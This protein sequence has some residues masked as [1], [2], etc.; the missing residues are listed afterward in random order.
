M[1]AS[2]RESVVRMLDGERSPEVFCSVPLTS[3]TWDQMEA[4]NVYYPDAHMDPDLMVKLAE[5]AYTLLGFQGVRSGF[6]SGMEAEAFGAEVNLGSRQNNVSVTKPAFDDPDAFAIPKNLFELGRFPVRFKAL[7]ILHDKYRDEVPIY[8]IV[9]GPMTLTGNLFGV[10]KIMRWI[11]KEQ[12]ILLRLLE[13]VTDVV[14][15][16]ANLAIAAGADA[17]CLGDPTA[18]GN[19]ISPLAFKKFLIPMYRKLSKDIKGRVILHIC[20]DTTF[21]LPFIPET[22]FCAFS[23]EGPS[24]KVKQAR[25]IIGNRMALFG[26]IPT[27][28]VMM[29]GTIEEVKR[30]ALKAIEDGI[31]SVAPS[32]GMALQTPMINAQALSETVR[33]YNKTKG[34]SQF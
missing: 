17:I 3:V 19:L 23:F 29:N 7:S 10:E 1:E 21:F 20:G 28:E 26:N 12:S 32:C 6:D 33:Q 22:G 9:T 13:Q 18:S 30:A 16:F 25:E 14:A 2:V 4:L 5:S 24:V 31:D 27:I 15:D 34:F 11:Y 8:A